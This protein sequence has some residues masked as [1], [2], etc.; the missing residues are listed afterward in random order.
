[1]KSKVGMYDHLMLL[2]KSKH[3][4]QTLHDPVLG[5]NL[6]DPVLGSNLHDP[7][8]VTFNFSSGGG[9]GDQFTIISLKS[10]RE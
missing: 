3:Q 4:G 1:M 10:P 7:V 2:K 5:S 8:L 9:G 6:H